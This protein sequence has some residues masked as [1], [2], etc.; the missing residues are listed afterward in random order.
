MRG[1]RS[2]VEIGRTSKTRRSANTNRLSGVC[3]SG[4]KAER[5]VAA[6]C[7]HSEHVMMMRL[8]TKDARALAAFLDNPQR[9]EGTL[10]LDEVR[11][12]LFTV[13][14]APEM[15]PP[16][17]WMPLIFNDSEAGYS[18]LREAEAT[19][20]WLMSLYNEIN[21]TVLEAS[22]PMRIGLEFREDVLS[23]LEEAA[24]VSQWSRGFSLGHDWLTEVWD[25]YL[26]DELDKEFGATMMTLSFFA[27][28]RLAEAYV[29][30]L[31]TTGGS[32]ALEDVASTMR[33]LF[34]EALTQYGH[35]GRSIYEARLTMERGEDEEQASS[36]K[37]GRN[38]PCPCGS[39][40]KHKRCC[41]VSGV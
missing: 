18:S 34:P 12:F 24:P 41:G 26:P 3:A 31:V 4:T 7:N 22:G 30:E 28:R 8:D 35:I 17:E 5:G 2:F 25:F 1:Q 32:E 20:G 38:E 40:K 23:N 19:L 33:E 6:L 37:V 39:G 16:S 11:G 9:P 27:S 13:A 15:I 36:P 21:V 14:S 29:A 10:R